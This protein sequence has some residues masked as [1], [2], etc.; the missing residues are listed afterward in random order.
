MRSHSPAQRNSSPQ[1]LSQ[2]CLN[3]NRQRFTCKP[4]PDSDLEYCASPDLT[5]CGTSPDSRPQSTHISE[6]TSKSCICSPS[7]PP[8]LKGKAGSK[9]PK[10]G[11]FRGPR[12]L[13]RHAR[14]LMRTW[15]L[16]QGEVWGYPGSALT[17]SRLGLR[18]LASGRRGEE[19]LG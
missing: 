7:V 13:S 10:L 3:C 5:D 11:R 17:K 14:K 9:F 8:I 18:F 6:Q 12:S 1:I 19:R 2:N 16:T 4:H 15:S